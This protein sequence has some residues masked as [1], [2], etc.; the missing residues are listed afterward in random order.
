MKRQIS[1]NCKIEVK[2]QGRQWGVY[3]NGVL[4]EGGFFD[5]A[6]AVDTAKYLKQREFEALKD[7][8]VSDHQ[9][10]LWNAS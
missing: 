4:V 7:R 1:P 5:R 9:E 10:A 8:Q 2:K 3:R 6:C